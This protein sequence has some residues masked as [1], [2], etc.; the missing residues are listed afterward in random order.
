MPLASILKAQPFPLRED[1][2]L[3]PWVQRW[4]LGTQVRMVE[5]RLDHRR[6]FDIGKDLQP[7][8]LYSRYG[9]MSILRKRLMR[10]AL[11]IAA[12]RSHAV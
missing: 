2:A 6:L 5:D 11:V 8:D 3:R 1:P 7:P 4:M 10:C 12:W 9:S